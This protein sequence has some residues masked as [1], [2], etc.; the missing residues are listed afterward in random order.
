MKRILSLAALT[1]ILMGLM[2]S[3]AQAQQM[4]ACATFQAVGL[5]RTDEPGQD[6]L[7]VDDPMGP[8]M[9]HLM[10]TVDRMTENDIE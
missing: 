6:L 2:L 7:V 5:D 4:D 1:A 3:L 10:E 9:H 8:E